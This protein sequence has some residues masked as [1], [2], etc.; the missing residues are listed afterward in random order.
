MSAPIHIREASRLLYDLR[1]EQGWDR[2]APVLSHL[3]VAELDT[4]VR[5]WQ[6]MAHPYQLRP[7]GVAR[8]M[9]MGGRGSGKSRGGAEDL[10]D[11]QEEWGPF[12]QY[13]L[14]MKPICKK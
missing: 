6:F 3:S 1:A 11:I 5:C 14:L 10:L 2:L 12:R 7:P 4:V 9:N 13:H 8:W